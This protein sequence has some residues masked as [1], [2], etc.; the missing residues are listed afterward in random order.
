MDTDNVAQ[1]FTGLGRFDLGAAQQLLLFVFLSSLT[2]AATL[3]QARAW[4]SSPG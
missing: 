4:A 2:G 3:I 1:R